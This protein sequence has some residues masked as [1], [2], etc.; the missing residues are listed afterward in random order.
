MR[1]RTADPLRLSRVA[2]RCA[3]LQLYEVV[4]TTVPYELDDIKSR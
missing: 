4:E 2:D 1:T 3:V